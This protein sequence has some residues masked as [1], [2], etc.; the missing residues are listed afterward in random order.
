MVPTILLTRDRRFAGA[1]GS[2]GGNAILAYVAK[3]LIAA[4]DWNMPMPEALA[5][6]NLV[7][8]GANFNGEVT[9][10]PPAVLEG[11]QQRGIDL[12][13]GQGEDSGVQGVL[14]RDGH[15][16]GGAD[17][18]REGVVLTLPAGS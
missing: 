6:P 2:A 5:A 12:K 17:P 11:L 7:A 3:S 14:I 8:R 13:P 9:E 4:I 15:I 1:I 10:F 18:R 16:D